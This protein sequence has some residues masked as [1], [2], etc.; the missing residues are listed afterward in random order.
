MPP[1]LTVTL[2][3]V[4]PEETLSLPPALTVV[5]VAVVPAS[6][7]PRAFCP[8]TATVPIDAAGRSANA[9]AY[10]A[11]SQS[12]VKRNCPVAPGSNVA[13]GAAGSASGKSVAA[14]QPRSP[15]CST[16]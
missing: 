2:F 12:H 6:K 16:R 10:S 8:E 7:K 5:A 3:T 9:T 11:S 1:G 14:P 4:P 15:A 13:E